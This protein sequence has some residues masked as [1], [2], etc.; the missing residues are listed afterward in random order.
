MR[1]FAKMAF[2]AK[3]PAAARGGKLRAK[4]EAIASAIPNNIKSILRNGSGQRGAPT[5]TG[6]QKRHPVSNEL[7]SQ[8]RSSRSRRSA[9]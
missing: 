6:K 3:P 4:P 9:A 1:F 8:R 5:G 2:M 7:Q